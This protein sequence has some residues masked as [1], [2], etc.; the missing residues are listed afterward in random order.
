MQ[1]VCTRPLLGGGGGG[2]G[3]AGDEATVIVEDQSY[4]DMVTATQ[5]F[6][7]QS[8]DVCTQ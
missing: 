1:T 3:G 2:G 6:K 8:P 7:S 5:V 4:R